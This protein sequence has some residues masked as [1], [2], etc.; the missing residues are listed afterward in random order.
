[1]GLQGCAG[2]PVSRPEGLGYAFVFFFSFP[3]NVYSAL[4]SVDSCYHVCLW[5]NKQWIPLYSRICSFWTHS[6]VAA[7]GVERTC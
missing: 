6:P 7:D 2:T 1:M 5:W 3:C 4:E